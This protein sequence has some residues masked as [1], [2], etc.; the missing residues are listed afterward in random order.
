MI[1][2]LV[3]QPSSGKDTVVE[4]LIKKHGFKHVSSGDI[5]RKFIAEN[6]LGEPTRELMQKTGNELRTKHGGEVLVQM[7]LKENV[8][9]LAI[10]GLRA[11]PEIEAVKNAGGEIWAV[12]A[13]IESRYQWALARGRVGEDVSFEEFKRIELAEAKNTDKNA[14]NVEEVVK[15]A[16]KRIVNDGTVEELE[17]KVDLSI[18]AV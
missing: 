3:G 8:E 15:M 1:I 5:I 4:F 9:R 10:S 11:I 6:N 18:K 2:G 16:D 7:A 17:S 13:P 12:E 14:Q